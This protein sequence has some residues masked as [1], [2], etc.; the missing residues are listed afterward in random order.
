M[1][2]LT[3]DEL[4]EVIGELAKHKGKHT[5]L[6]SVYISEGYDVNSVQKQL[7]AE[8]STAKNI[9]SS[10]TRKNVVDALDKIVRQLKTL[11]RTPENGLVLFC[12]NV[13]D[14][15]GQQDLQLWDIEPPMPLKIRLYRC[16]KEFVLEPLQLMI[17][18]SEVFGLLVMDRKEAAIGLLEGKRIEVLQKMT[19]G[20]P[21]KIRA[22]GQCLSSDTLIMKEDGEILEIEKSHNPLII[23]SENFNQ[24]KIEKTPLIAKWENNKELFKITTNYPKFEIKSSKEHTFF[25]R[26][27]R[28]IEEKT[29][30]EIKEGDYLIMPEKINLNLINQKIDFI[31]EIK[32]QFNM[33]AV[34]I[35]EEVNYS[36]AKI[37]GYYLGDGNYEFDR[38]SFS[39]QREDVARYYSDLIKTNFGIDSDL[40]FREDKNY[41]QLRVY[42]R[43]LSQ[44]FRQILPEK[45]KTLNGR[46]PLIILKSSD[47]SLAG[48][49]SGFF[50]AEGYVSKKRVAFG[51]NNKLLTQQFQFALLRLG[52]IS[53]INEYDNRKNPYSDKIRYTLTID[54]LESLR[55]FY[56]LIGFSSLEKQNKVKDLINKRSNRNKVRQLVVNGSEIARIIRNSGLNTRD[57]HCGYFFCNKRQMSKDIFKR[58]ILEKIK[59][60]DLKKRLELFYNS[61]LIALKISKIEP[62]GMHKTIDIETKNHNFIANGLLVHNSSQRFHRIT[63]GLTKEFYKRIADGMKKIFFDMPRLKGILI[64]G[65]VPTKDEFIEGGYLVTKLREKLIG[66]VDI[67]GSDE[68]GLKELVEKSQDILADQEIIHEKKILEKFFETLGERPNLATRGEELTRNALK[69]GAVETLLLSKKINTKISKELINMAK[70]TGSNVEIISVDT[71]E[72]EQFNNL[73]G[74]GAILRFRV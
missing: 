57:F 37:W 21:S 46:I 26:T 7:E 47:D 67:G 73:S 13:S 65:P 36:L 72:G 39:E 8:K 62:I 29:L 33:K 45:N 22:G 28:G 69:F 12:G 27:E 10:A 30:G 49:I 71:S 11:K 23:L 31:P 1:T 74:I 53:S 41:W 50:D 42:S 17:E 54:D 59:D 44:L 25:V 68:S 14:T 15:E 34:I 52:I 51:I 70:N 9:K 55:K 32:Q 56:D 48:F 66:R 18:I 43:I 64:G 58:K 3:K 38:I 4:E 2:K 20:V 6:I 19:S 5:E 63:E 61:N 16:D 35:P 60:S 24:E 40:K